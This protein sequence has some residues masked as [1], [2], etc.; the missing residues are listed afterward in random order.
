MKFRYTFVANLS[1]NRIDTDEADC[2]LPLP[3]TNG[4]MWRKQVQYKVFF[5]P[6][7]FSYF[8]EKMNK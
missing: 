1:V 5:S 8:D 7:P 6:Y 2:S 3:K 4:E